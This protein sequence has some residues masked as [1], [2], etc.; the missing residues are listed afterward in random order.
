VEVRA[1]FVDLLR[2]GETRDAHD[3]FHGALERELNLLLARCDELVAYNHGNE[4]RLSAEISTRILWLRRTITL[5]V[6]LAVVCGVILA[7][8]LRARLRQ[9]REVEQQR[10]RF[11]IA[12]PFNSSKE[13]ELEEFPRGFTRRKSALPRLGPHPVGLDGF[14]TG[15]CAARRSTSLFDTPI[16]PAIVFSLTT[17][18]WLS[19][20][21]RSTP[22]RSTHFTW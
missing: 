17:S 2:W 6:A 3:L 11:G 16:R 7:L 20:V 10:L 9:E 13:R 18:G 21:W 4:M 5:T 8:N 15:M 19:G 14:S 22:S 12:L 1:R